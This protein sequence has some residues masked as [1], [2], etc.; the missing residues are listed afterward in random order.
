MTKHD[1]IVAIDP[2][3]EKSGV[4]TLRT[5][6]KYLVCESL[7]FP[8]VLEH[9]LFCKNMAEKN[10]NYLLIIV[11]AGWIN[12][13]NWHLHPRDTKALAAAKGNS[14]GRNHE[15]GRKIV[16]MCK[17]YNLDVVEQ[18]PLKKCWNGQDG[19]I[20]QQEIEHFI[21]NFP[22]RSNQEVRD[23]ALIAWNY[24]GYPIRVKAAVWRK[25]RTLA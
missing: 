20:T 23:A 14:V 6:D 1:Y 15:T 19:K 25:G 3:C 9:L 11:E 18:K 8:K 21:P 12:G 4:V 16:E 5:S 22:R 13:S 10:E 2:D 17:H 24:A 7:T